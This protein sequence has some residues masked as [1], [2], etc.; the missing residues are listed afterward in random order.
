METIDNIVRE[1]REHAK[2]GKFVNGYEVGRIAD[3]I[4]ASTEKM[5]VIVKAVLGCEGVKTCI[6]RG[7]DSCRW[8]D[9]GCNSKA[10]VEAVKA[11]KG[12]ETGGDGR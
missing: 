4:R 10:V 7:C 5:A 3:R 11:Y 2:D 6:E 9:G 1:M 12:T 8:N